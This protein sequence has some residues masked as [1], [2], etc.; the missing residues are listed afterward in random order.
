LRDA[1]KLAN[2]IAKCGER[3]TEPVVRVQD[4]WIDAALVQGLIE[5]LQDVVK[6]QT[7]RE[8]AGEYE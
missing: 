8:R 5:D 3:E 1:A 2:A 4:Y 7:E 6:E